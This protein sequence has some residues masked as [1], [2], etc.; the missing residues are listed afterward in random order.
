MWNHL[1]YVS[2]QGFLNRIPPHTRSTSCHIQGPLFWQEHLDFSLG[3]LHPDPQSLRIRWG[4]FHLQ[5]GTHHP[6]LANQS[7][8]HGFR[9]G[10]GP[11]PGQWESA[12]ALAGTMRKQA[13]LC[14][15]SYAGRMGLMGKPCLRRKPALR[16]SCVSF[17]P[18]VH[19]TQTCT[20]EANSSF[21]PGHFSL[22]LWHV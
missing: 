20:T 7:H 14:W 4:W 19:V 15:G 10:T 6:S 8:H 11:R 16:E 17:P 1:S 3:A 5:K 13:L 2:L 12:W 18:A 21:V 9:M 22:G